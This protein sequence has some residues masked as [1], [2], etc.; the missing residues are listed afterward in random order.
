MKGEIQKMGGWCAHC[1][2]KSFYA[3]MYLLFRV[4]IAWVLLSSEV[5][6]IIMAV[7]LQRF[8]IMTMQYEAAFLVAAFQKFSICL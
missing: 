1:I 7:V 5:K 6:F 8:L 2:S 3:F 4:R